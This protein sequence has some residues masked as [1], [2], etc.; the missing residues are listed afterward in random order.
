MPR[1]LFQSPALPSSFT[2][3]GP[4]SLTIRKR[5]RSDPPCP[6]WCKLTP[7]IVRQGRGSIQYNHCIDRYCIEE[8]E[9]TDETHR[10]MT[11]W[12][13][14]TRITASPRERRRG[15]WGFA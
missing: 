12:R 6:P 7:A 13:S 1:E 3:T 10:I 15:L 5:R 9:V 11:Y 2:Q 8:L 14:D 4:P